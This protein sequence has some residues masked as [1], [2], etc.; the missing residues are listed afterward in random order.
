[1]RNLK[2]LFVV[3]FVVVAFS[4]QKEEK[5]KHFGT[6]FFTSGTI[7]EYWDNVGEVI[8]DYETDECQKKEKITFSKNTYTSYS[9]EKQDNGTCSESVVEVPYNYD[10]KTFSFSI[11]GKTY[12]Y[13][14]LIINGSLL[15]E[16]KLENGKKFTKFYNKR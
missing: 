13:K 8:T 6:W 11:N 3:L 15:I 10:G 14:M 4:C 5:D 12:T 9:Y 1:M 16:G 2:K 7:I